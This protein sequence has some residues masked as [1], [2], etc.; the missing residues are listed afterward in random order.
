MKS[1]A[2]TGDIISQEIIYLPK[3]D[4]N[5]EDIPE[6]GNLVELAE[7][8]AEGIGSVAGKLHDLLLGPSNSK[9]EE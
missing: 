2:E 4:D 1:S 9:T 8:I 3:N 5:K 6:K 7:N